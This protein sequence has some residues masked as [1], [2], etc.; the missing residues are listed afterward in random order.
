MLPRK[1]PVQ[2]G[3]S[4]DGE[5]LLKK[6]SVGCFISSS[7]SSTE[8]STATEANTMPK[9]C[10]KS[11]SSI[12]D[13][14][15]SNLSSASIRVLPDMAFG[16]GNP[17]DIDEDLHSRQLAAY[18]RET[19]RWLFTSNVLVSGMQGLGVEIVNILQNQGTTKGLKLGN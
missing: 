15:S 2:E 7:E 3:D 11:D 4:S 10:N 9:D 13:S 1:R 14:S 18:G 5:N 17:M 16:N 19:M 6:H 8:K 12:I